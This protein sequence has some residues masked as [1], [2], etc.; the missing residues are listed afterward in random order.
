MVVFKL[1]TNTSIDYIKRIIAL[2][3]ETVQVKG[4]RLFLNGEMVPRKEIRTIEVVNTLT[5][6]K[7]LIE[8]TET[9]PGGVEHSIYEEG[10][11]EPLDNTP[12]YRIPEGH[13]FLMGDNR[14]NSQ[15]SRVGDLVGDVP[16]ENLVGKADFLF[17]ST[18][19]KA[20]LFEIWKWPQSIRYSRIFTDIGP[21]KSAQDFE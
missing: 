2:P 11:A 1:P 19:G 17:F 16:F 15:D 8:Y 10:D 13:Y 4:G 5:G 18:N 9:L 20:K 7:P 14:D 21:K 3:G 12:L 6:R